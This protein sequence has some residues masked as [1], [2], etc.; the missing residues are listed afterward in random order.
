MAASL[1]DSKAPMTRT[2]SLRLLL[3]SMTS[4]GANS[5][6]T[7]S[8]SLVVIEIVGHQAAAPSSTAAPLRAAGFFAAFFRS[9]YT[10]DATTAG[11]V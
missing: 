6:A 7:I 8:R 1:R 10:F 5:R 2:G 3:D 9:E 11:V 4:H